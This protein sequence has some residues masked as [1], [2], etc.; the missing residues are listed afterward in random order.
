MAHQFLPGNQHTAAECGFRIIPSCLGAIL[1]WVIG[2]PMALASP[3]DCQ[4]VDLT[5]SNTMEGIA[6][7]KEASLPTLSLTLTR[8]RDIFGELAPAQNL[9]ATPL[10]RSIRYARGNGEMT[11]IQNVEACEDQS[12]RK[13]AFVNQAMIKGT[14]K[15]LLKYSSQV[16][17]GPALAYHGRRLM[18]KTRTTLPDWTGPRERTAT[19]I[20]PIQE[21]ATPDQSK[22]IHLP[23]GPTL[24][25][26]L[27]SSEDH[28]TFAMGSLRTSSRLPVSESFGMNM[29]TTTQALHGGNCANGCP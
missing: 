4:T 3:T 1:L 9:D 28:P 12:P 21:Q 15:N 25:G 7:A 6:G 20:G 13:N 19:I 10:T 14:G 26:S 22:I 5:R 8:Q 2:S 11:A 23:Q 17:R 16:M 18:L 27:A 29:T 24:A